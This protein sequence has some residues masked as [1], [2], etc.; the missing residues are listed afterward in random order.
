MKKMEQSDIVLGVGAILVALVLA[1]GPVAQSIT[2]PAK[3]NPAVVVTDLDKEVAAA[4]GEDKDGA[5]QY[6]DFYDAVVLVLEDGKYSPLEV[7]RAVDPA[8][9][10]LPTEKGRLSKIVIRL[11]D[12]F[13]RA[14][15]SEISHIDFRKLIIL[16]SK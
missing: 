2:K 14:T 11:F 12:P 7:H 4:F 15:T 6:A 13:V 3:P 10:H 5:G 16:L 9:M 8:I 1:L